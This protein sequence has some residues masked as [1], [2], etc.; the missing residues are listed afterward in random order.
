MTSSRH[1][2]F[3]KDFFCLVPF[4]IKERI[5]SDMTIHYHAG[6]P[7]VEHNL[8]DLRAELDTKSNFLDIKFVVLGLPQLKT[9]VS[10]SAPSGE[11]NHDQLG[12]DRIRLLGQ[13]PGSEL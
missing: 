10:Q 13:E 11:K 9:L 7:N 4:F 2:N 1:Q 5:G 3:L 6:C 8:H 12:R